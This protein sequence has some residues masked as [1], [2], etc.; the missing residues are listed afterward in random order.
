MNM[1][2]STKKILIVIL[3]VGWTFSNLNIMSESGGK[4]NAIMDDPNSTNLTL[5]VNPI[6]FTFGAKIGEYVILEITKLHGMDIGGYLE[7]GYTM[8]Y[9][10]I[11]Q[12]QD[13]LNFFETISHANGTIKSNDW[14]NLTKA[15]LTIPYFFT[16]TNMTLI[17]DTFADTYWNINVNSTSVHLQKDAVN[18][19]VDSSMLVDLV[20]DR[21]SGW[22]TW[23]SNVEHHHNGTLLTQMELRGVNIEPPITTTTTTPPT[24]TTTPPTTTTTPPTTT[25][26][27]P[28]TTTTPPTTTT[29]QPT[30]TT[31]QPTTT[32]SHPPTTNSTTETTTEDT[33]TESTNDTTTD[34]SSSQTTT[35]QPT[36]QITFG[37]SYLISLFVIGIIIVRRKRNT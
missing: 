5:P 26:T 30:T 35:T 9:T 8:N 16:T 3:L 33:T 29:T 14:Y 12:D 28:T 24:T 23:L 6:H 21:A 19:T 34:N 10:L 17:L 13:E 2:S 32:T 31:T 27:P 36:I 37:G 20:F 11:Y 7:L 15:E 18:Y 4:L 25:T 1:K 22:L